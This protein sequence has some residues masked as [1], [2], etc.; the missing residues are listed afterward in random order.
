MFPEAQ[1]ADNERR[2]P[3]VPSNDFVVGEWW[4]LNFSNATMLSTRKLRA[5]PSCTVTA[6]PFASSHRLPNAERFSAMYIGVRCV[7]DSK[8]VKAENFSI[9]TLIG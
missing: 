3:E 6:T 2:P 8:K 7:A 1:Y 4:R 9:Y 5:G